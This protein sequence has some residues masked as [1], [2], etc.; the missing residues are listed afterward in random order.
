M[1]ILRL[2]INE[3]TLPAM[4]VI[5]PPALPRRPAKELRMPYIT[6][7]VRLCIWRQEY[8][9]TTSVVRVVLTRPW[10]TALRAAFVAMS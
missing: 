6:V 3:D 4:V 2:E 1:S 10:T 7:S 8:K 9:L 5:A